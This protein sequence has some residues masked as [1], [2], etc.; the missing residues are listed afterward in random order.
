MSE[1]VYLLKHDCHPNIPQGDILPERYTTWDMNGLTYNVGKKGKII[2]E[3]DGDEVLF[4]T[5]TVQVINSTINETPEESQNKRGRHIMSISKDYPN[6]WYIGAESLPYALGPENW[7]NKLEQVVDQCLRI[8][9]NDPDMFE[10]ATENAWANV[11]IEG[12]DNPETE[13]YEVFKSRANLPYNNN[14]W[15]LKKNLKKGKSPQYITVVDIANTERTGCFT[16][17]QGA[18][19]SVGIR[20]WPYYMNEHVYGVSASFGDAGVK[21]FHKG[22]NITPRRTW[23]KFHTC[24][25][26]STQTDIYDVRGGVFTVTTPIC[27]VDEKGWVVIPQSS[28]FLESLREYN[29]FLTEKGIILPNIDLM[30]GKMYF[31]LLKI[32]MGQDKKHILTMEVHETGLKVKKVITI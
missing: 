21:V 19:V 9:F 1:Y 6:P 12:F 15:T 24:I 17:E 14:S 25:V 8:A 10:K 11:N 28:D 29:E 30:N 26:K 23:N 2:L 22:G 32:K 3:K 7:F 31:N 27:T 20:L 4:R 18:L 13:A 5:P 16:I